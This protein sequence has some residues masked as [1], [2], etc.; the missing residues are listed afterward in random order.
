[1][2]LYSTRYRAY[3]IRVHI[4]IYMY[5]LSNTYIYTRGAANVIGR[6]LGAG[7]QVGRLVGWLAGRVGGGGWE[8]EEVR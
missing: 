6:Y 8:G 4:Y 2:V 5:A 3:D 1:M 7:R